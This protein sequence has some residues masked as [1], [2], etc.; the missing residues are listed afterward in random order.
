MVSEMQ[1]SMIESRSDKTHS[2]QWDITEFLKSLLKIWWLFLIIGAAFGLLGIFI[3]SINKPVYKS[4]LTF[5]LD[6]G[7]G[8]SIG[9]L[10]SIASQFGINLGDG[11]DI[12][13]GDNI[14]EI[15]KSRRMIERVLLSADTFNSKPYTIA[16]YYLELNKAYEPKSLIKDVH[17][18]IGQERNSFSYRQDSI[19][20]L[21]YVDFRD[22]RISAGRPDKK[23][24]IYEV[25]V[26]TPDEKLTKDFTDRLVGETNN[27]YVEIRTKKGK[28]TLEVLE[29]RVASMKGNLNSS[30]SE[31][32]AVQDINLNPA[33]SQ[34]QVPVIKQQTNIQAYGGA[35]GEL[36]KNLEL[37][38]FQYLNQIPLMQIIDNA[39]YPMEK[40][41]KG[42][43]KTGLTFA[44]SAAFIF[45]FIIW[46]RRVVK[47][48]PNH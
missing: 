44:I 29:Q 36:F 5:A 40:I 21:L 41:K 10:M 22:K 28:E 14:L 27:Y 13:A 19:L 34:A 31:R 37:A 11:K 9:G 6:E 12:F 43:L 26:A 24:G 48:N 25:N 33:F 35:Y 3:A 2:S 8:S 30:I 7:G 4:R 32:A 23:L 16:E 46:I 1:E 15:M 18:P 45:A 42:K 17:F 20:Y 38:R 39:D 47:Y